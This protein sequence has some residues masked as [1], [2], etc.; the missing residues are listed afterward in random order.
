MA[1]DFTLTNE[2]TALRQT[3][4]DFAQNVLKPIAIKA[5]AESDPQRAFAMMKPAYKEAHKLGLTFSFIPREYGG[6][7]ATNLDTQI[8]AE[9]ICAVDPG[10]G[11]V[12]LVN[13]LALMPLIWYGTDA[14]KRKW[15][16]EA[17]NDET[18]EYIAGF[19]VSEA[20]GTANFDHPSAHSGLQMTA[21]LDKKNGEYVLNGAKYWPSSSGGWDLQGANVN[22][23]IVRTDSEKGGKEGLSSI[24]V[25]RGTP[26]M[27]FKPPIDT[28]GHRTNQN[29]WVEF[30]NCRV[31]EENAFAIGDGD[32][33]IS[34]AFTWSG[35]VAGI[36]AVGV[37]RAAYEW[38]MEWAKTYTAGGDKPIINYQNVGYMLADIAMEIEA[39]RYLCWKA[40]HYL[41]EYQEE[42]QAFGAMAKIFA[43]ELLFKTV[44]K[45]MQVTGVN[46]LSNESP[47]GRY[48]RE[49]ATFPIYDAGTMGMQRRKVWGVMAD[50]EFDTNAFRD[51]RPVK[52]KKSMEG[53]GL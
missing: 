19:N 10:F 53:W 39:S 43:T 9:E 25:P 16:D 24:L 46:S 8:V 17:L 32:L 31:P 1:I 51:N 22:L 27:S 40:A 23:F 11:C 18:G 45:C 41:D 2:Q 21:K 49:A 44:Y 6:L 36:A 13:G 47:L 4:H 34:K 28:F 50:P 3:A 35:P 48:L 33:I 7:G 38:T 26:G 5:D 20:A 42:G 14:Q 29:N 12:L 52:F 37:A 15:L 30:D